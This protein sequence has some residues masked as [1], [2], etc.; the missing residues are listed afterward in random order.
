MNVVFTRETLP[1]LVMRFAFIPGTCHAWHIPMSIT[2]IAF[3]L[4][5][6]V[7]CLF[8]G[9]TVAREL[10]VK[11]PALTQSGDSS[12]SRQSVNWL[13]ATAF[14]AALLICFVLI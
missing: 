10:D 14:S 8:A 5:A 12:L 4:M 6:G 7:A 11:M 13:G 2:V 3:A 1:G 9:A